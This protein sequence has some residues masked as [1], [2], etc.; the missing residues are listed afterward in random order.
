MPQLT[1]AADVGVLVRAAASEFGPLTQILFRRYPEA[2]WATFARF[3]WRE[4]PTGLVVTLSAI[5]PPRPGDLDA[6]V[7]HVAIDEQYSLRI[8]LGA[9]GHALAVGVVHSHPVGYRTDPSAIDDDMDTYYGD[10]FADFA[11]HRPYVSLILARNAAGELSATGRVYWHGL[12]H[13]VRRFAVEQ[14]F[15]GC[16]R[17]GTRPELSDTSARRVARLISAFG[18]EAADRLSQATVAVVG[19]G[20]TGSPVVE[21]LARA[22][23][24]AIV[25]VD[26]D[27][28]TDS[29]LERL[30]GSTAAD[31]DRAPAKVEIMHRLVASINPACR[32]TAI[33]GALPQEA[34]VDT[35]VHADVVLGC[36]DRQSSRLALADL[37]IR[38][39]VPV[40]DVGVG[41]EGAQ[42]LVTGQIVQLVRFSPVD[43]CPYCRRL[44]DPRRVSQELMSHEERAQRRHLA[45][46]AER[47]GEKPAAYWQE[48]PQ[49]HTVGY[50]T[51][52]A[53]GMAAGYAIGWLT[54]RFEMPFTK[55]QLNLSAPDLEVMSLDDVVT[56]ECRCQMMRGMADQAESDAFVTAPPHWPT[57]VFFN[58]IAAT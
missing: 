1:P 35:L 25:T 5:D 48:E 32:Q 55:V 3:G 21:M 16:G 9:E 17:Y 57:P 15:V 46:E 37:A 12:W 43:P 30:H 14:Q 42:G 40:L 44:V 4:T 56:P 11:P 22:G 10:Y 45:N 49:L 20:G 26:P 39:L 8:A 47:R 34:V 54:G 23:V 58:D 2:E 38:Y 50:L 13:Q 33:I 52:L 7:D 29:N 51:T 19:A 41:L 53:G 31:V 6:N 28:F 18:A 27:H 36:T 24:G